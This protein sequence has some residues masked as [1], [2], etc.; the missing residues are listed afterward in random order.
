MFVQIID[1]TLA[2]H[3]ADATAIDPFV[4]QTLQ[5][6]NSDI[7]PHLRSHLTDFQYHD[8]LLTYQNCVYIPPTG[9]LRRDIISRCHD[10]VSAGHPG[11][12][13]TRQLVAA[14][15]WWPGLAQFI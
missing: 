8:N 7:P 14:D 6:L 11:Y 5:I 3:I 4:K 15:Y 10:H 13:K 1:C 2:A 9:T 12:L